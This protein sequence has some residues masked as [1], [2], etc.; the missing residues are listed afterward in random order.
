M[1]QKDF[2]AATMR[3]K[4]ASQDIHWALSVLDNPTS[5]LQDYDLTPEETGT[6]FQQIH[7]LV[8]EIHTAQAHVLL[9]R[10]NVQ[11]QDK[12]VQIVGPIPPWLNPDAIVGPVE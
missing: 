11:I 9:K 1:S 6:L 2:E 12:K 8:A 3:L 10:V 4:Q 5:G 7:S